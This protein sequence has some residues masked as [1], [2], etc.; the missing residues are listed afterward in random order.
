MKRHSKSPLMSHQ[1][2]EAP[3]DPGASIEGWCL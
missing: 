3:V 1:E 2:K